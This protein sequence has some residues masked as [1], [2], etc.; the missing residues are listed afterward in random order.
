M[1]LIKQKQ[2]VR[3]ITLFY[4]IP[5]W[6]RVSIDLNAFCLYRFVYQL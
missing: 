6:M 3:R 4:P 2:N 1:C 5:N